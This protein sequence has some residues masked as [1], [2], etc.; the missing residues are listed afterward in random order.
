MPVDY[1]VGNCTR[2]ECHQPKQL[3]VFSRDLLV[4]PMF[5]EDVMEWDFRVSARDLT[6]CW[7]FYNKYQGTKFSLAY[8]ICFYLGGPYLNRREQFINLVS[9]LN[10]AHPKE[11]I[12]EKVRGGFDLEELDHMVEMEGTLHSFVLEKTW[13]GRQIAT[14]RE[15]GK[16]TP[17]EYLESKRFGLALFVMYELSP[18]T[19]RLEGRA[20]CCKYTDEH[21]WCLMDSSER[22]IKF[23]SP[24]GRTMQVWNPHRTF[25]A[26]QVLKAYRL[27]RETDIDSDP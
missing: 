1:W 10:E 13:T 17:L 19:K 12:T 25:V 27:G 11:M 24:T 16:K 21:G 7:H 3:K 22:H 9:Q 26:A 15:N 2:D 4:G 18:S 8:A 20:F 6:T 23:V 14:L 5:N